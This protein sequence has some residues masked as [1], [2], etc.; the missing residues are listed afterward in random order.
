MAS[1]EDIK[2]R[3]NIV[4]IVEQYVRL[5]KT[6]TSYKARCP[7]HNERTPSFNVNPDRQMYYCF[8]CGA[9]GDI[10]DFIQRIE[11]L[12]FVGSMKFLADQ[13]G[14]EF[15]TRSQS[16]TSEQKQ[17]LYNAVEDACVWFQEKLAQ[18]SDARSYLAR[19]GVS[20]ASNTVWRVGYA[21][22]EWRALRE[23]LTANGYSDAILREAGLIKD[24][25]DGVTEK[26]QPFD[27]FRGRIIF[28]INDSSGRCV[29]FSGR[30]LAEKEQAPKYLNS[31]DTPIFNKS[32]VLYGLDKAKQAIRSM[33]F[34]V[35][36]EGQMD[37]VLSHQHGFRNTVATSG[38]AVTYEHCKRLQ[39]I[40]PKLMLAFDADN[41]GI[42]AVKKT[43]SIALSLGMD[44][45]VAHTPEGKDP[46][47]LLQEDPSQWKRSL[48]QAVHV[49]D[50]LVTTS[51]E[52]ANDERSRV[53]EIR[54]QVLPY[55]AGLPSKSEQSHFISRIAGR[56]NIREDAL[57]QDLEKT[58]S[59]TQDYG[60]MNDV[61]DAQKGASTQQN[62]T[63][64]SLSTR[65]EL[66][67]RH[68]V[69]IY[70]SQK[71]A[72]ESVIDIAV[73]EKDIQKRLGDEM[74]EWKEVVQSEP[75]TLF[76]V[77]IHYSSDVLYQ[78]MVD[79][80]LTQL[81]IVLLREQFDHATQE[82]AQ[83]ERVGDEKKIQT[84]LRRCNDLRLK[85]DTLAGETP[86]G[87]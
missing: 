5:E 22:D 29:G 85:I 8:G 40:S 84:A 55:I 3:V 27:T 58:V 33:G 31:P 7:F 36:V 83:A 59:I 45:K 26:K 70:L 25:R 64:E 52:N 15:E 35:L 41:A 6:G 34:S 73:L 86:S 20:D 62:V 2:S 19:R 44:V 80:L 74:M 72:E 32:D 24:P 77:D 14:L 68:L 67:I 38:T 16:N 87:G 81:D 1:V 65:K 71:Q 21:P 12:D 79:D 11:G 75:E 13:V 39:R 56:V 17:Y 69:G 49:I 4:D 23:Y 9:G 46:A 28:P 76:I 60:N 47:D 30:L 53:R 50:F 57:W 10:V 37:I 48:Q 42:K 63:Y 78:H 82:L 43:A 18:N 66:I 61:E 51:L 54:E